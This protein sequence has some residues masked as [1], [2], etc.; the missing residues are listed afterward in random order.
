MEANNQTQTVS[1]DLQFEEISSFAGAT[2]WDLDF[3]QLEP[4]RMKIHLKSLSTSRVGIF[5]IAMSHKLH[6]RGVA[7]TG[8]LTFGVPLTGTE[9]WYGAGA[10]AAA[11]LNFNDESG[12]DSITESQFSGIQFSIFSENLEQT[13][14]NMGVLLPDSLYQPTFPAVFDFTAAT[15]RFRSSILRLI[16]TSAEPIDEDT[17]SSLICSLID[18]ASDG[19]SMNSRARLPTRSRT[20]AR[21]IEYLEER[22]TDNITVE[23]ICKDTGASISTLERA[24]KERFGITPKTYIRLRRLSGVRQD[25]LTRRNWGTVA[26]IASSWG[27]THLSQFAKDY[28]KMFD[29]LPSETLSK[30]NAM[31]GPL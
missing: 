11:V 3:R 5:R 23:D 29:E 18:C 27:F 6:Q 2:G 16:E 25:L 21:A 14:T 31:I 17:E 7:P 4:G 9:M 19:A 1:R 20:V 8:M 28:R 12:F 30:K 10:S 26:D 22:F 15:N 24:F 13:A